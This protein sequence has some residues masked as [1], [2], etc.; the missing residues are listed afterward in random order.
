MK[1]IL[2]SKVSYRRLPIIYL[3]SILGH[4]ASYYI[5]DSHLT[6]YQYVTS[7]HLPNY[8][9]TN[10]YFMFILGHQAS[11]HIINNH[12]TNYQYV[13]YNHLPDY[14]I[15]KWPI[16]YSHLA[17]YRYFFLIYSWSPTLLLGEK[18]NKS[19]SQNVNEEKINFLFFLNFILF[20]NFFSHINKITYILKTYDCCQ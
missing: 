9:V 16:I 8:C 1:V 12:L 19:Y 10:I 5:T 4:R 14:Y 20:F 2:S 11:Y 15:T 18:Y 7:N 13:T 6:G 3:M 17:R